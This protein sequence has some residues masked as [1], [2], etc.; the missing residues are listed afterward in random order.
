MKFFL[1]SFVLLAVL[2][3]GVS[4]ADEKAKAVHELSEWKFGETLFGEAVMK[5]NLNGK[6]VVLGYWGAKCASSL[7]EMSH[8]AALDGQY[9]EKGLRVIGAEAYR[10]GKKQIKAA[11]DSKKLK[12]SITDG[13][14]GPI[15]IMGLPHAVIFG[16]D[17]K[18]L[19]SGH[20]NDKKFDQ[21]IKGAVGKVR[22]VPGKVVIS[23]RLKASK[24][25]TWRNHEGKPLVA[26]LE[27]VEEDEVI[28]K[29][30]N[31]TKVPYK[32]KKLSRED[33][34][35]IRAKAVGATD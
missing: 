14:K 25:R 10:S 16:P 17:G 12:F 11:V 9:R 7:E 2:L 30:K 24:M 5:E 3:L 29:L 8:F 19:F 22:E 31:G 6:V 28:F 26:S 33:Q 27:K 34:K 23:S 1:L 4:Q 21:V 18:L 13:V 20:P 15:A 32:I 35:L